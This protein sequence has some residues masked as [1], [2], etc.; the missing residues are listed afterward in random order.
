MDLHSRNWH[1]NHGEL[2]DTYEDRGTAEEVELR[3]VAT[4]KEHREAQ[5]KRRQEVMELAEAEQKFR[6]VLSAGL[7]QHQAMASTEALYMASMSVFMKHKAINKY[8][9]SEESWNQQVKSFLT[10]EIEQELPEPAD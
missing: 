3:Q 9:L 5:Q 6:K 10:S 4:E 7:Q 2:A 8:G 1:Q